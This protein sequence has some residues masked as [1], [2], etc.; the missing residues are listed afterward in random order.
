M[1]DISSDSHLV[2]SIQ[3]L[4]GNATKQQNS[5]S[6]HTATTQR[7]GSTKTSRR[8]LL[9]SMSPAH[10]A[11]LLADKKV[12]L[13]ESDGTHRG[14]I[15]NKNYKASFHRWGVYTIIEPE[16]TATTIDN[17]IITYNVSK[18]KRSNGIPIAFIDIGAN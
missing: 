1:S 12:P 15:N 3:D 13:F 7:T 6:E 16:P 17:D 14:F 9:S 2:R 11:A 8:P 4:L 10:P 5:N 18:G